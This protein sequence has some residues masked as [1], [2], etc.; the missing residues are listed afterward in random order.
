[1]PKYLRD[2]FRLQPV[3]SSGKVCSIG[4]NTAAGCLIQTAYGGIPVHPA[5]PWTSWE[6]AQK[7]FCITFD[8]TNRIF[9][10]WIIFP[11]PGI[12]KASR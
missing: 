5:S 10:Y 6:T 9:G 4:K 11:A 3:F 1:M 8:Y 2:L 7:R 12:M